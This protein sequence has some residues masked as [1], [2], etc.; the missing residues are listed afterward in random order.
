[1]KNV[2]AWVA[3]D[4]FEKMCREASIHAPLET[5]GVLMGYWSKESTEVV[6][7]ECVEAGPASVHR[8]TA[9]SPDHDYQN[10]EIARIYG[11][12][13]RITTY[14]GDWHSHPNESSYLSRSDRRTLMR[15]V[16]SR[17][18]RAPIAL[19]AVLAGGN[20]W[21]LAIL[22]GSSLRS[23]FGTRKLVIDPCQVTYF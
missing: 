17:T 5:G 13:G 3:I 1:M 9:F 19:M 10:K 4:V 18:A 22:S 23:Y 21:R 15:I 7:T 14:L 8:M 11:E 12:S 2:I 6:V 20:P 16:A